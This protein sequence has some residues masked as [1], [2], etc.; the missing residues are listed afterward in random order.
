MPTFFELIS[1]LYFL[2]FINIMVMRELGK[3]IKRAGL[4]APSRA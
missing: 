2:Q 1:S 3:F 4:S